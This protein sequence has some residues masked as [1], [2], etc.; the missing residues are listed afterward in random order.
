MSLGFIDEISRTQGIPRRDLIE[1]DLLLHRLLHRLSRQPE[2]KENYLFK[3]GTC[4][5][6][7]HLPKKL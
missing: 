2:F 3:G 5:I 7:G 4:L 6:K 1:K